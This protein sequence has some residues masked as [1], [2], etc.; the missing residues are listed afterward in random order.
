MSLLDCQ[1]FTGVGNL[2]ESCKLCQTA[3]LR[4]RYGRPNVPFSPLQL[5]PP[6]GTRVTA[7]LN[8]HTHLQVKPQNTAEHRYTDLQVKPQT[9][10]NTGTPICCTTS[11]TTQAPVDN[12]CQNTTVITAVYLSAT[13]R[14]YCTVYISTVSTGSHCTRFTTLSWLL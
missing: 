1:A 4:V 13:L 12:I 11:Q 2:N 5:N 3:H 7:C 6:A 8:T 10:Q 14:T 9:Q